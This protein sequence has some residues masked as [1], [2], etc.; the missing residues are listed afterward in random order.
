MSLTAGAILSEMNPVH[1]NPYYLF[2]IHLSSYIERIHPISRPFVTFR[3][4]LIL[5]GEKLLDP[6]CTTTPCRLSATA[7]LHSWGPSIS[8]IPRTHHAMVIM[9]PCN[10]GRYAGSYL[11]TNIFH[12][13]TILCAKFRE[14]RL[15][16]F[17]SVFLCKSRRSSVGIATGYRLDGRGVGVQATS[18]PMCTGGSFPESKATGAWSWPLT[19][20]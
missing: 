4:K 8:S 12:Y 19:S 6:R 14:N 3:N 5:Y 7:T 17:T 1:T 2:K 18:Y 15:H 11:D 9:D 10:K 20:N 16:S 13:L